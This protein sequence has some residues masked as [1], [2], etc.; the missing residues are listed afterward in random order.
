MV[1]PKIQPPI[2]RINV[3]VYVEDHKWML[4]RY[5]HLNVAEQIR[6]MVRRHR[7]HIEAKEMLQD[8][9]RALKQSLK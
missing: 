6:D 7:K 3:Q 9:L 1:R 5:G 2:K 4:E 8:Q